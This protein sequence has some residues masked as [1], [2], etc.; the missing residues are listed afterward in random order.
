MGFLAIIS[1]MDGGEHEYMDVENN[2][3][4]GQ[5]TGE[6]MRCKLYENGCFTISMDQQKKIYRWLHPPL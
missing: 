2:T 1:T 4:K 5:F 3:R 6:T